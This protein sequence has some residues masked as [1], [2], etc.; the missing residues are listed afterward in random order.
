MKSINGVHQPSDMVIKQ[1]YIPT[2]DDYDAY[3][4]SQIG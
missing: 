2:A 4:S 3:Q 1:E